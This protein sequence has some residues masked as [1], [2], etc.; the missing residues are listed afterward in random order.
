MPANLDITDGVVSYVGARKPAWHVLGKTFEDQEALTAHQV[1][2]EGHLGG[3]NVR[4]IPLFAD[5]EGNRLEVPGRSAVIRDNPVVP[6]RV[7]VLGDV[8]ANYTPIQNETHEALLDALVDDSGAKYDTAGALDGGKRVFITMRLPGSMKVGGVGGDEHENY[9]TALNSHD[10]SMAF[11]FMVT[12]VRVVCGNTWN[13]AI[14]N[15]SASFRIRHTTNSTKGI[16]AAVAQALDL[17]YTYLDDF[18]ELGD[19]M[20]Q[21]PLSQPTFEQIIEANYGAPEDAAAAVQTRAQTKLDQMTELFADSYTNHEIGGTVWAGLN[22]LT[23]WNDHYSPSRGSDRDASR[24]QKAV[25]DTGFKSKAL[26]LMMAQVP[27][28]AGR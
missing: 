14:N 21:T 10:G 19:L 16:T 12:P 11:T 22:A 8:G 27:A 4:K 5:Y 17:T 6:G 13:M 20:V 28:L 26:D 25:L 3:W 9:I 15:H 23:E 1:M 7:D 24:A 18:K 2:T